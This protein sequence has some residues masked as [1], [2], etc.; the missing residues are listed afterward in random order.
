[1][2]NLYTNNVILLVVSLY[3][4]ACASSV[5]KVEYAQKPESR[6]HLDAND[7]ADIA[8]ETASGIS[9]VEYEKQRLAQRIKEKLDELKLANQ[10]SGVATQYDVKLTVT[11]YEKG[12]AFAR[13]ML[14]GLGQIHLE[15]TVLLF[16]HD[17]KEKLADFKVVKTFAWG[18]I[19][20]AS[21]T[22]EDLEPP[23]AEAIA[24]A[25]AGLPETDN[26]KAK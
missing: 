16:S 25:L 6:I 26:S 13:A 20:G 17:S 14:A 22:M 21:T 24:R 15:A 10:D 2:E 11:R 23:F 4:T 7:Q 12:S 9:M 19:Y 1:M 8:I 3:L 5:P 18:G